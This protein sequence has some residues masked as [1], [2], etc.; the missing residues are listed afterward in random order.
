MK[1]HHLILTRYWNRRRITHS[2]WRLS[3]AERSTSVRPMLRAQ[4]NADSGQANLSAWG[5]AGFQVSPL[6]SQTNQGVRCAGH[7]PRKG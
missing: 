2:Q 6:R 5:A 3:C 4:N 7:G 1:W